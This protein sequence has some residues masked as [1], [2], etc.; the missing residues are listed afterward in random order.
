MYSGKIIGS[1]ILCMVM[2]KIQASGSVGIMLKKEPRFELIQQESYLFQNESM[3]YSIQKEVLFD[4]P[5]Q[6]IK[7]RR[8]GGII[9]GT[10]LGSLGIGA[11]LLSIGGLNNTE[12]KIGAIVNNIFGLEPPPFDYRSRRMMFASIPFLTYTLVGIPLGSVWMHRGRK[13]KELRTF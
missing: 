7:K 9:L 13:M 8:N 1:I 5:C 2:L 6:E 4:K 12:S 3:E 11:T 10:S